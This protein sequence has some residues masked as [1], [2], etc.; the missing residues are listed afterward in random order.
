MIYN[1]IDYSI[2]NT[3]ELIENYRKNK[4]L[5]IKENK[6]K[7]GQYYSDEKIAR[8]MAS[9]FN[10]PSKNKIRLLDP[11]C[12][13]GILT[14]AFLEKVLQLKESKVKV[15]SVTMYEIDN[16]VIETLRNNMNKLCEECRI[17]GIKLKYIIRNENFIKRFSNIEDLN[18]ERY[19]YVIMNPPYMK[20]PVESNDN[21][22]LEGLGIKVPNYYA[23]F[24]SLSKRLLV[25][26]GE[27]VAITPRSF[28]N[29]A[30]FL[31]FR[32]DLLSD[33][34]F[35]KIHLFESRTE[36]FKSDD[37]LQENII[38]HCIK[39]EAKKKDKINI[40]HTYGDKFNELSV[41]VRRFEDIV[42]PN[43]N[44]LIIRILK[45][46]EEKEITTRINSLTCKLEDLNI[47]VSTGPVVDFREPKEFQSKERIEDSIP[48][49]FSE[50]LSTE[51]IT[52][53]K[54]NVKKYNYIR[55]SEENINR[56]RLN[57]NYVLVKRMTSKEEKRRIV[58]ALCI[59]K[60]YDFEFF[61]FD[62][63]VNYF[64][65]NKQGLPLNIAKGLV[66]FLNSTIIDRYFR[67]FSG[68]TQVNV[69]DLKGLNYPTETQLELLGERYEDIYQNQ[70]LIDMRIEEI[71]F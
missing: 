25:E 71:L 19:D 32:E 39:K 49:F 17:R 15:I 43:D 33:M 29:G 51:G 12:G 24:I 57:G 70:D 48:F 35:D 9:M 59:G 50:H 53:P 30:Y 27:L 13:F 18:S 55:L 23:A 34:M 11:G 44:N 40:L 67:T 26:K 14:A 63:K 7:Y 61:A 66:I 69:T 6:E 1:E 38:F 21:K 28:C 68:N 4:D 54:I 16:N 47:Q 3:N 52:W 36:L 5:L 46:N 2:N 20:L 45:D 31:G 37:I 10:K 42:F 65:R 64:H 41:S 62:N 8:Y 22:V 60:N 58:S 56:M